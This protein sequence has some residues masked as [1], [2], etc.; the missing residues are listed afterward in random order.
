MVS[1]NVVPA[2]RDG[3]VVVRLQKVEVDGSTSPLARRAASLDEAGRYSETFVL[4]DTTAGAR[5][6]AT[7]WFRKDA[8]HASGSAKVFFTIDP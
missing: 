7:T 3:D 5:Y 8:D 6:R 2:H 4:P 1:G